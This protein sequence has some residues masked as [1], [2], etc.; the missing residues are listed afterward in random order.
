MRPK[1]EKGR[2]LIVNGFDRLSAPYIVE[3]SDSLGFD[4]DKDPGVSYGNNISLCGHQKTFNRWAGGKEGAGSLGDSSGEME[5]QTVA[6][7]TFD[8]PYIHGQAIQAAGHWGFVSCSR[9][10]FDEFIEGE[11]PLVSPAKI[12]QLSAYRCIDLLM[13]LQKHDKYTLKSY[14]TFSNKMQR[15]LR[16]YTMIGGNIFASGSYI[17]SDMSQSK[18]NV[19]FCKDVLKYEYDGSITDNN[20]YTSASGNNLYCSMMR[21]MNNKKYA[22]TSPESL[23]PQGTALPIMKYEGYNKTAAV[24][25]NGKDYRSC[26]LGFPFESINDES[27]RNSLMNMILRTFESRH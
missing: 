18:A 21:K 12:K 5:G 13:G 3:T 15:I 9:E 2:V 24:F 27:T 10:Y 16:S 8:Y 23:N 11:E 25:Y 14:T 17:G 26:V 19:N 6:G 20:T 4:I 7:N 22:V 1:R